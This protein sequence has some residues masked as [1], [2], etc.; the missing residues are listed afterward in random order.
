MMVEKFCRCACGEKAFL[1]AMQIGVCFIM[2]PVLLLLISIAFI[3]CVSFLL[4]LSL[5]D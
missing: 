5:I 2:V 3:L 4:M 1:M